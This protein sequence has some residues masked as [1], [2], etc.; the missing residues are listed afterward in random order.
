MVN[1]FETPSDKHDTVFEQPTST[2]SVAKVPSDSQC[3]TRLSATEDNVLPVSAQ[4]AAP[5]YAVQQEHNPILGLGQS[6]TNLEDSLNRLVNGLI[7]KGFTFVTAEASPQ[8]MHEQLNKFDERRLSLGDR[9]FGFLIS[10]SDMPEFAKTITQRVV[11]FGAEDVDDKAL[12]TFQELMR[13]NFPLCAFAF[14]GMYGPR[15]VAIVSGD[16]IEQ[17]E[18]FEAMDRFQQVN[19]CLME[20]GGRL[21]L[22]LFGKSLLGINSSSATGSMILVTSTTERANIMRQWVR[23]KPLRND[24]MTNQLKEMA[25]RWQFWA[26]AAIGMIEYKPHQ[27]RQ[28]VIVLDAQTKQATSTASPRLGFEFGFALEEITRA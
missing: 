11:A 14:T 9:I 20:L 24:T 7:S 10:G 18:L 6:Q 4:Q 21:S 8:Q 15:F 28:E 25:T 12:A 26:K 2:V 22:K 3:G 16:S 1:V 19:L 13:S 17:L 5:V 23:S 27:L